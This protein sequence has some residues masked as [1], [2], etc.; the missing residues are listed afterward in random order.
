MWELLYSNRFLFCLLPFY[1]LKP[2]PQP[3]KM[4]TAD[5][6]PSN[7]PPEV[8][9]RTCLPPPKQNQACIR[10]VSA[11]QGPSAVMSTEVKPSVVSNLK[12]LKKKFQKKRS[13]SQDHMYTEVDV[14]ARGGNTENEYQEITQEE[15]ISSAP[16]SNTHH[17]VPL[18]DGALPQEYMPPPPFAPG[19]WCTVVPIEKHNQ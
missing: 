17:N 5:N 1:D 15:A 9:A 7:Q 10:T 2:M 19:Y 8:P 4:Y 12:N 14:E 11:P 3:R 13:T 16:F 18:T 6:S